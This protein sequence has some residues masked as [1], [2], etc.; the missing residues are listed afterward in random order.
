[1]PDYFARQLPP[2]NASTA[3][4][5][6]RFTQSFRQLSLAYADRKIPPG[7]ALQH[8]RTPLAIS[9]LLERDVFDAEPSPP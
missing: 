1:M 8:T 5:N 2:M 9:T 4:A 3:A 6:A 7:R